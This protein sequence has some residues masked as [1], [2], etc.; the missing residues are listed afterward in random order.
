ML[1]Q[2]SV[3]SH[4]TLAD[5][6]KLSAEQERHLAAAI[7]CLVWLGFVLLY[8]NQFLR[9]SRN[10]LPPPR[11]SGR[12]TTV[13]AVILSSPTAF[14][15]SSM[16]YQIQG[17]IQST[18]ILQGKGTNYTASY[19]FRM[20]V[21]NHLWI[22]RLIELGD[23]ADASRIAYT[24]IGTDGTDIYTIRALKPVGPGRP[25][26]NPVINT[27][28]GE[29]E[30]L[31]VPV[32]DGC[33]QISVLWLAYASGPMFSTNRSGKLPALFLPTGNGDILRHLGFQQSGIWHLDPSAPHLPMEAAFYS[34]GKYR[35]WENRDEAWVKPPMIRSYFSPYDLG[36]T[37]AHYRANRFTN[38]AGINLPSSAE[39]TVLTP[40]RGGKSTNDLHV[41]QHYVVNATNCLAAEALA[42]RS[43]VPRQP[44]GVAHVGDLRFIHE[45]K[46]VFAFPYL[47]T[48]GWLTMQQAAKRVGYKEQLHEQKILIEIL[49]D[50]RKSKWRRIGMAAFCVIAVTSTAVILLTKAGKRYKTLETNGKEQ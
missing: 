4:G 42:R 35:I 2:N 49:D 13:I 12:L 9:T 21:S 32:V 43:F 6:A 25:L 23:A 1:V 48:N 37:N 8:I 16:S 36:F 46:P 45:A 7:A 11:P 17:N 31:N 3:A 19:G 10:S 27:S 5:A 47:Q 40:R 34:D 22:A 24:E 29:I 38:V 20:V 26:W 18:S 39:F 50:R 44:P 14:S 30:R 15:Q 33:G 28:T 41:I